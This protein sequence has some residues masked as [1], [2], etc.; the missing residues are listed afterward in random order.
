MVIT[1]LRAKFGHRT[2]RRL[3]GVWKQKNKQT[4]NYY[5]DIRLACV[6]RPV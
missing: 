3:G 2:M 4:V 5:I 1:R 6:A